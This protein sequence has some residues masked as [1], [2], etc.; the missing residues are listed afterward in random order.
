MVD[1]RL[2]KA[3]TP[4]YRR[5]T[6]ALILASLVV[7]ANLY[8]IHPLLPL[9]AQHYEVSTLQAGSAFTVTTLT[10][11]LSLLLHGPLSDAV[12]RRMPLLLGLAAAALLSL[13]MAFTRDFSVLLGLRAA[14]GVALGVLPAIAV[15]Y[16][17]DTMDRATLVSAVGLYIGGTT[18]G[19][20][21]GRLLG[22]FIAEQVGLQA[23]FLTLGLGSLAGLLVVARLLPTPLA[24][25]PQR[26]SFRQSSGAVAR[27]LANPV[28]LAAFVLGG[29]NFMVFINLYT[30]LAFRLSEAPWQL[31]S[32]T[33]GLLF[34]T[35]LA[36]TFSAAFSGRIPVTSLPAGMAAGLVLL[37]AGTLMLLSSS[38]T[39]I[40]AGLLLNATGFFLTHSLA[41]T[42]VNRRAQFSKAS[43]SSLYSVFYYFGAGLGLYY[44]N[45]FWTRWHW[46]AVVAASLGVLLINLLIVIYLQYSTRS[47]GPE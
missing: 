5:A 10:L 25:Q 18:L 2:I 33:L 24:F 13:A 36:G 32:G 8:A 22:G 3:G 28:L 47:S 6:L 40:I 37:C 27:H 41:N 12:G 39:V 26:F 17:G 16:L 34:L 44:L 30:F 29:L 46:P 38:V 20:A 14:L 35:Y 42:W 11:G 45:L 43:A 23:V 9:I 31:G 1:E 21:G 15:A 7:F 19:G 4:A